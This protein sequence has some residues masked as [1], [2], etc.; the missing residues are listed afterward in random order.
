MIIVL[1]DSNRIYACDNSAFSGVG[2]KGNHEFNLDFKEINSESELS[3][4]K[5]LNF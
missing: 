3:I 5:G 1:T 2:T 4:K